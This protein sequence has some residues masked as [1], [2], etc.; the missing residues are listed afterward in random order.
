MSR[1]NPNTEMSNPCTR[2][3]EWSGSQGEIKYYDKEA[4]KT[5]FLGSKFGFMVLDTLSLITGYNKRMKSGITSNEVRDSRHEPFTVRYFKGD[6]IAEGLYSEIKDKVTS[7]SV[8]GKWTTNLYIAYKGDDGTP[9]L[10]SLKLSG[11]AFGAWMDFQKIHTRRVI[12]E[13]AVKIDGYLEDSSG[14]VAFRT[15]VFKI[16]EVSEESAA[17]AT[18]IDRDILQPYLRSYLKRS[19]TQ[20]TESFGDGPEDDE[21]EVFEQNDSFAQQ[22]AKRRESQE[23]LDAETAT[24]RNRPAILDRPQ[25]PSDDEDDDIPF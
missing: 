20:G 7:K 8:G 4:E 12:E 3:F 11:A 2:W 21:D 18:A 15:P 9:K 23:A 24:S 5:V 17:I 16:A 19:R 14:D 6:T 13:K 22:E 10:G 1:S 25:Y